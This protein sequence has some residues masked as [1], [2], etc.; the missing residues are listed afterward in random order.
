MHN[1]RIGKPYAGSV[2]I[3]LIFFYI[4]IIELI[5][6]LKIPFNSLSGSVKYLNKFNRISENLHNRLYYLHNCSA[7]RFVYETI[8]IY[9]KS[10]IMWGE[11]HE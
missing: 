4:G 3:L 7:K 1:S 8:V 5:R 11:N 10:I 2:A 9:C 6:E